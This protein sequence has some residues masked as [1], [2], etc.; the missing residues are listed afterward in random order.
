MKVFFNKNLIKKDYISFLT[1]LLWCPDFT[2]FWENIKQIKDRYKEGRKTIKLSNEKDCDYFVYPKYFKLELSNEVKKYSHEAKKYNKKVILFYYGE[3]DDYIKISD[4]ILR[5][6]RS[7]KRSN[8]KNEF[9]LPPFPEDLLP[10]NDNK[11]TYISPWK[12]KY[13][14]WYTWYSN[15]SS[16]LWFFRYLAVRCIWLISRLRPLKYLLMR[17]QKEDLY[18]TLV[19]AWTWNYCRGKMIKSIKKTKKY[20]FNFTQRKHA[21]TTDTAKNMREEYINNLINSDFPLLI[22]WFWNYS[23]RQYEV[24]SL[25][26]IPIYIDTWAKLP[27]EDQIAYDKLFIIVPFKDISNIENYIDTYIKKNK[28]NFAAIQQKIRNIY[29]EYFTMESYYT[30]IISSLKNK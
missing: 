17:I 22:R 7:T 9:C 1:P 10:Y 24:M 14:I 2:I 13:S 5:Y 26:K 11:I 28:W 30:K 21:L 12:S 8:P 4:N 19:N 27:F 18:A 15:Y 29:K 23:V 3:I 6:K 25:G 20:I 16:I